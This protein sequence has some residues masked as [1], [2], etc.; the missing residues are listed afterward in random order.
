MR[1]LLLCL[2]M[3]DVGYA[4]VKDSAGC[5]NYRNLAAR[6]VSRIKPERNLALYRRL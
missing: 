3:S 4:C 1:F 2:R 5:V 6:S